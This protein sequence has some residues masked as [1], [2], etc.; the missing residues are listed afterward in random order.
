MTGE[1]YLFIGTVLAGITGVICPSIL[2]FKYLCN[3]VRDI[4][5]GIKRGNGSIHDEISYPLV[6]RLN[7]RTEPRTE[8]TMK[9]QNESTE[10]VTEVASDA[11][12]P[13]YEL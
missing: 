2:L 11:L 8:R 7:P 4:D 10:T 9:D 12:L 5:E 13:P 3:W 6:Y 1:T